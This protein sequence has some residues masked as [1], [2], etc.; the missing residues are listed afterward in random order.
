[1]AVARE[2][3]R[4]YVLVRGL[5]GLRPMVHAWRMGPPYEEIRTGCGLLLPRDFTMRWAVATHQH[6]DHLPYC[7]RCWRG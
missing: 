7:R 3:S 1:M 6:V 5:T 4:Y 2:V